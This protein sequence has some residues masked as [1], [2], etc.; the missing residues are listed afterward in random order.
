MKINELL[1][2]S[3]SSKVFQ[4]MGN[5]LLQIGKDADKIKK[6]DPETLKQ[7]IVKKLEQIDDPKLTHATRT[8][9]QKVVEFN[10]NNPKTMAAI[11]GFTFAIIARVSMQVSHHYGLSPTQA[12]LIIEA[13]LPTLGN[14]LGYL[15]NGFSVKD[16][17]QAGLI[18]GTIGVGGT[19]AA[20][21]AL[22]EFARNDDDRDD[23]PGFL[24]WNEFIGD[25]K[26]ILEDHFDVVE[27]V[28]KSTIQARFVPHDP[29]EFGPTLLYSYYEARAG[30]NKGAVSRRGAI[31][32][33]KYVPNTSGLGK[34]NYITTF[35]LLKGHP[36]ERHFDL[37]GENVQ[38][39]ADIIIGNTEGAY[40]MQQ[41]QVQR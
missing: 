18:A 11:F 26:A 7:G 40:Q 14:F 21:G 23:G 29:M 16:S 24:S 8:F 22:T 4:S 20:S 2:E 41:K 17:V 33:G 30:R 37:T 10:R 9:L 32:V 39:I 27:K 1:V 36:F 3:T 34:Q 35:N 13:T 28:V 25:L 6:H 12:T 31:Q 15:V 38:K 19:I 5:Q